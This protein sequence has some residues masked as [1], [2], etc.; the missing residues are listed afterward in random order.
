VRQ[1]TKAYETVQK[2]K[3]ICRES[4]DRKAAEAMLKAQG[5]WYEWV[6]AIRAYQDLPLAQH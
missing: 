1:S 3:A 5:Y 4:K 2:A 6:R